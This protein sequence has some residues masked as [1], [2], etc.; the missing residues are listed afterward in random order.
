M[1]TLGLVVGARSVAS[2]WATGQALHGAGAGEVHVRRPGRDEVVPRASAPH[3]CRRAPEHAELEVGKADRPADAARILIV[4]ELLSRHA[5][6][7]VRPDEVLPR[8]IA[9]HEVDDHAAEGRIRA[10]VDVVALDVVAAATTLELAGLPDKILQERPGLVVI[11]GPEE[12]IDGLCVDEFG[13]RS[14]T[15]SQA[16]SCDSGRGGVKHAPGRG[17]QERQSC[18]KGG[19]KEHLE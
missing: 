1:Y 4:R 3:G 10:P 16:L 17:G 2:V 19:G 14:I 18:H 15:S 8:P 6:V 13:G 7:G 5:D 12:A 11:N 9:R